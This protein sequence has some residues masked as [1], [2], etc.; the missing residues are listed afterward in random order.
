MREGAT[1]QDLIRERDKMSVDEGGVDE[2]YRGFRVLRLLAL[3]STLTAPL[4]TKTLTK[5][6]LGSHKEPAQPVIGFIW[7]EDQ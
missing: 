4:P 2:I 5:N 3:R 1:G 7:N 6:S